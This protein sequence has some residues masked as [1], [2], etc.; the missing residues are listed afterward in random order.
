MC[1]GESSGSLTSSPR[2]SVRILAMQLCQQESAEGTSE[3]VTEEHL[4]KTLQRSEFKSELKHTA[5]PGSQMSMHSHFIDS[6]QLDTAD[7]ATDIDNS[8]ARKS[9]S[10]QDV[11]E[12]VRR[13][14]RLMAK[15]DNLL[16]MSPAASTSSVCPVYT[17]YLFSI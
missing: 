10:R 16:L 17:S 3:T 7:S 4:P 2:R 8:P 13:S 6:R 12:T 14:P 9:P 11:I 1:P 15:Q 5:S